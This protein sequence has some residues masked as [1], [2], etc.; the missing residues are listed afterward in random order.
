MTTLFRRDHD[1]LLPTPFTAGPWRPDAQHGGPPSALLGRAIEH[2]AESGEEVVRVAIELIRPVPL[3][4]LRVIADRRGVSRRVAH[5]EAR[6]EIADGG[7]R[8]G[9][10]VATARGLLLATSEMPTPEYLADESTPLID[11]ESLALVPN[12]SSRTDGVAYHRDAVEHRPLSGGFG[13]PGPADQWIRLLGS[14]VEGEP[15]SP[16][17]RVLAAADFG[18]GISAIFDYETGVGL[19]NADITVAVQRPLIGEWVRLQSTTRLGPAGVGVCTTILS[20]EQGPVG[21]AIQS[22]LAVSSA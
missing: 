15:T 1:R 12:F 8:D 7:D 4:A 14:L 9:D 20:D 13:I 2:V 6:I 19:I 22:L 18:S 11:A 3:V 21:S 17:S 16:L 5:V 10:V